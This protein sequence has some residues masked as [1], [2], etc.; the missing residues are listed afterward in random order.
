MT[1]DVKLFSIMMM[2]FLLMVMILTSIFTIRYEHF[3][4]QTNDTKVTTIEFD[5]DDFVWQ[6][7]KHIDRR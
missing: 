7:N 5:N 1:K 3:D 4:E 2:A 6:V